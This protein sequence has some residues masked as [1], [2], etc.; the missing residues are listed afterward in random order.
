VMSSMI[1]G[2]YLIIK[3]VILED[4]T[5]VGGMATIAPGTIIRHDT[6]IGALSTTTYNQVLD[7]NWI[8]FGIPGIKLKK[9]KY[10]QIRRDIIT[11]RSVD[12]ET[13]IE[14]T[15]EVNIDDDKKELIKTKESEG[16]HVNS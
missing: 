10:A 8:Y 14:T 9:N 4:Y 1:V 11:K 12:D 3:R 7:P 15:T 16:K 5:I 13:K 6:L 2:K